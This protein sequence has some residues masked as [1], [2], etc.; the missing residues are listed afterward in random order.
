MAVLAELAAVLVAVLAAEANH[1]VADKCY[2]YSKGYQ[3]DTLVEK[4][5]A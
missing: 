2:V 5:S 4:I 1:R 3:F